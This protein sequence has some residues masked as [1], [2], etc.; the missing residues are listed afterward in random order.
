MHK[1]ALHYSLS[2][3]AGDRGL[4]HPLMDLLAAVARGGSISAAAKDLGYSYRHAWGE[5]KRWEGEL[6]NPLIVWGK[7]Q[8]A[9]LTEFGTKLL[10]AE[11]QAQA[12][13]APQIES[14]RAEL[15]RT[16]AVAFDPRA[17]MLSLYASHDE[18]LVTLR[19]FAAGHGP[20]QGLHLDIRPAAT[21]DALRA[22][23]EGR[24]IMA[25]LHAPAAIAPRSPLAAAYKPLLRPGQHKIIGFVERTQGLIVARGNPLSVWSLADVARTGARFVGRADGSGTRHLTRT[26]LARAGLAESDLHTVDPAEPSHAAVAQAVAAGLGDVGVGIESAARA[27]NLDFVP[28]ERE[29]FHLVCLKSELEQPAVRALRS[30]LA[31]PAWARHLSSVAGCEPARSGQVLSLR[32]VMPWWNLR[33]KAATTATGAA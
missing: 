7:G 5:L 2:Q 30:L 12:R 3:S 18:A 32:A 19:E 33:P 24:C 25:A 16:F 20:D 8:S 17:H 13:L 4:R 1:V 31:G 29:A 14:L 11:R 28:L 23:N 10:W 22:L 15:E 9:R 26:W 27:Q 6:A 21:L